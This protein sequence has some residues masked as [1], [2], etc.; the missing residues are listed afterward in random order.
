MEDAIRL[1]LANNER[2]LKAPLRVEQAEGQLQ[3]AR[4]AFLPSLTAAG[5]GTWR[6]TEDRSGRSTTTNGTLTLSQPI[7]A[8]SAYVLYS[9]SGHQG[10]CSASSGR[11]SR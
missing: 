6:A 4:S 5:S 8:P 11:A 10:P 9:Q 7:V 2:A 3:R 1:S